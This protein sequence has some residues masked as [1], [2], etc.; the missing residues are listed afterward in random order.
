MSLF[1]SSTE[2]PRRSRLMFRGCHHSSSLGDT[3]TTFYEVGRRVSRAGEGCAES[4]RWH[5]GRGLRE[6]R[7]HVNLIFRMRRRLGIITSSRI[8]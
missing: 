8:H 1:Y 2:R 6:A 4:Q 7:Y 3:A 5:A